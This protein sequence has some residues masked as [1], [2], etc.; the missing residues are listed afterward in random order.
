M[1]YFNVPT[2]L[3]SIRGVKSTPTDFP[4]SRQL[5][6]RQRP[7]YEARKNRLFG[8]IK[9]RR[10]RVP[11][12]LPPALSPAGKLVTPFDGVLPAHVR[13]R[14]LEVLQSRTSMFDSSS[15]QMFFAN[16]RSLQLNENA[17]FD[18]IW[19]FVLANAGNLFA[20]TT[21]LSP[22][23]RSLVLEAFHAQIRE[24]FFQRPL[25]IQS[26]IELLSS[27]GL[28][29]DNEWAF[30]IALMAKAVYQALHGL[31]EM[32]I[33]KRLALLFDT[34]IPLH[35]LLQAWGSFLN[36]SVGASNAP[37]DSIVFETRFR[38]NPVDT[39]QQTHQH[40]PQL[41]ERRFLLQCGLEDYDMHGITA[42]R[43]VTASLMTMAAMTTWLAEVRPDARLAFTPGNSMDPT[44]ESSA[45]G[46]FNVR[47]ISQGEFSFLYMVVAAALGSSAN[48][49]MLRS[50]LAD[51][52]LSP[53]HTDLLATSLRKL[54]TQSGAIGALASNGYPYG[55]M[56]RGASAHPHT[57]AAHALLYAIKRAANI[58]QLARIRD[59]ID[60]IHVK[61]HRVNLDTTMPI[62]FRQYLALHAPEQ[63]LELLTDNN[64][65][66]P[67]KSYTEQIAA[68]YLRKTDLEGFESFC[69]IAHEKNQRISDYS[70]EQYYQLAGQDRGLTVWRNNIAL[71]G[72]PFFLRRA[73]QC[74]S[75][76]MDLVSFVK[77][78]Q[79]GVS[80]F[81]W[82][83]RDLQQKKVELLMNFGQAAIAKAVIDEGLDSEMN[84]R[85]L[86]ENMPGPNSIQSWHSMVYSTINNLLHEGNEEQAESYLRLVGE[87]EHANADT[88]RLFMRHYLA[89][90]DLR[91]SGRYAERLRRIG[92]LPDDMDAS[93][94]L[95]CNLED[96]HML[97][98]QPTPTEIY[99]AIK[100][101]FAFRYGTRSEVDALRTHWQTDFAQHDLESREML[102]IDREKQTLIDIERT[103][104]AMMR[105][106]L[107]K[108]YEKELANEHAVSLSINGEQDGKPEH[109]V[110]VRRP[111]IVIARGPYTLSPRVRDALMLDNYRRRE[112]G[113][114]KAPSAEAYESLLTEALFKL[115]NLNQPVL[116]GGDYFARCFTHGIEFRYVW[117]RF[118]NQFFEEYL[119]QHDIPEDALRAIRVMKFSSFSSIKLET[120]SNV[121]IK[122]Q[123]AR[124]VLM[125]A[126]M[127]QDKLWSAKVVELGTAVKLSADKIQGMRVE[128]G[129]IQPSEKMISLVEKIVRWSRNDIERAEDEFEDLKAGRTFD[130]TE[131]V[132]VKFRDLKAGRTF[133]ATE[134]VKVKFRDL[135]A[136]RTFDITP[137]RPVIDF[138][139]QWW[140]FRLQRADL[141]RWSSALDLIDIERQ[142]YNVKL[143]ALLSTSER[144]VPDH[145]AARRNSAKI[146]LVPSATP[147]AG[148]NALG[149]RIVA[150]RELGKHEVR[151]SGCTR[152]ARR[153]M[154][155][156]NMRKRDARRS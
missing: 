130:V 61:N 111:H 15:R 132:K 77:A 69:K 27:K 99:G 14:T 137:Y 49:I 76:Q 13:R 28:L 123:L 82:I 81:Q 104:L 114:E 146:T 55:K 56:L 9:Y 94:H 44:E 86:S 17:H 101:A 149:R 156:R 103:Y 72:S 7:D 112:Y 34:S 8:N 65:L 50:G 47:T 147:T 80:N 4:R 11:P 83:P 45:Q 1:R 140:T 43:I 19:D 12:T 62:L 92:E 127:L 10:S 128:L 97:T 90:R 35:V 136:G 31:D 152:S 93:R 96:L 151:P 131:T 121:G 116:L 63:A 135:N 129:E 113:G 120:L 153:A 57:R 71:H 100:A 59:A 110:R 85:R 5:R 109:H 134:R 39:I 6:A 67:S 54:Q 138:S 91:A 108:G 107:D 141:W 46:P 58:D 87:A 3:K 66:Q 23:E 139:Y 70:F 20:S 32:P 106:L 95:L 68:Y 155:A 37:R 33:E 122:G 78:W 117:K 2:D 98:R 144:P 75:D 22:N 126:A 40:E 53:A 24:R 79:I 29:D 74:C 142:W 41:Y 48:S 154:I 143:N 25:V 30:C 148:R 115:Q 38:G 18:V 26:A 150:A 119:G 21:E 16:L 105:A 60:N 73:L 118:A 89:T 125:R 64:Y 84:A 133:G 88:Y 36:R 124:R 42:R 51:M 52:G 102:A 145:P